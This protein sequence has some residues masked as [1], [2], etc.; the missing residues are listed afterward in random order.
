MGRRRPLG[1]Y[2]PAASVAL[3]DSRCLD[4]GPLPCSGRLSGQATIDLTMWSGEQGP[5]AVRSTLTLM[6][7]YR[8]ELNENPGSQVI[9]E[10]GRQA[11][12]PNV[13]AALRVEIANLL[14]EEDGIDLKLWTGLLDAGQPSAIR[15]LAAALL[16]NGPD[17]KALETLRNVAQ[18]PNREIAVQVATIIQKY[19]RIDMGLPLGGPMPDPTSKRTAE[20]ARSVIDWASG[21]AVAPGEHHSSRRKRITS[22]VRQ[23]PRPPDEKPKRRT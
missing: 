14:V 18:V 15:L 12:N 10:L 2:S 19:L 22:M 23:I 4:D 16:R 20:I 3:S 21:K 13:P 1:H 8:R 7:H 9:E 5:I 17:E 6:A 11:S